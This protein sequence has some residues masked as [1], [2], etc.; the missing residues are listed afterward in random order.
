M[1]R[2]ARGAADKIKACCA[3]RPLPRVGPNPDPD[4]NGANWSSDA[5]DAHGD[6]LK[7]N[8]SSNPLLNDH[9]GHIHI[10]RSAK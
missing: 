8:R 4:R 7:D 5:A 2:N 3:R 1:L 9:N 6:I 10:F